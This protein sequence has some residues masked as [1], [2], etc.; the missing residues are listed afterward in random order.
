ML[1]PFRTVPVSCAAGPSRHPGGCRPRQLGWPRSL[2]RGSLALRPRFAA[3]VPCLAG[4]ARWQWRFRW[5]TPL[6]L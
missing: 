4:A 3:G 5:P 1:R 6:A 2:S